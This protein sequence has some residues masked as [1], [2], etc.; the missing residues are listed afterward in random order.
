MS[1]IPKIQNVPSKDITL[2][3][4]RQ[5]VKIK[6]F[7]VKQEKILIMA[8]EEEE[9]K[10]E[11]YVNAMS[12]VIHDCTFGKVKATTLAQADLEYIFM[13]IRMMSK[14]NKSEFKYRCLADV[15]GETCNTLIPVIV[16]LKDVELKTDEEHK[17]LFQIPNN[18]IYIQMKYPSI[19][20]SAKLEES[21]IDVTNVT[22]M[23]WSQVE[24]LIVSCIDSIIEGDKNSANTY[25]DLKKEDLIDWLEDVPSDTLEEIV[26]VF[27]AKVPY[28]AYDLN[29]T[30][31]K[32]GTKHEIELRG[33]ENFFA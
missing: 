1:K 26:K 2:P 4:S 25:S 16:D 30:C 13:Q 29:M 21:G 27:F 7:L 14:G 6:P 18:D 32:C 31:P 3:L 9:N 19:D 17:T 23:K 11:A 15:N 8:R 5:K 22:E 24:E 10:T 28:L 20:M 12:Q 33:I